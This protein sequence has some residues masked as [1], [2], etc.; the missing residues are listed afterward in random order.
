MPGLG[1]HLVDLGRLHAVE[2]ESDK[3]GEPSV[4]RHLVESESARLY[5]NEDGTLLL[6]WGGKLRVLDWL[7]G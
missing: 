5:C 1:S 6:A 2:Y 3:E 4:Y 7:H